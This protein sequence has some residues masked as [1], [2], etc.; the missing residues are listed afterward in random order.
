MKCGKPVAEEETEY[1]RDCAKHNLAFDQGKSVWVHRG[2]VSKAIYQFKYKNK[3]N[4]GKIFA[5]EMAEKY[6]GQIKRWGIQEIVPV[7]I[8]KKRRR[9]RGYNQAE[10][11]A[12]EIGKIVK[13]PVNKNAI[14]RVR[15]TAPQKNLDHAKRAEN[16]KGAFQISTE[17]KPQKTVL[18]IDDIYTTGSTIHRIAQLLKENGVEKVYFLTISIGQER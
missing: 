6:K 7:P 3:R 11:L 18:L 9:K 15:N 2:S 16:L 1:C 10:I 17:F 4:Y 5:R 8:H 12:D 14:A 13:I